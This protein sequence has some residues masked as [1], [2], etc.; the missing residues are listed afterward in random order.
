VTVRSYYRCDPLSS[1]QVLKT[2]HLKLVHELFVVE[3]GALFAAGAAANFLPIAAAVAD[4]DQKRGVVAVRPDPLLAKHAISS[5]RVGRRL[6]RRLEIF[7][8][9]DAA[10]RA[11]VDVCIDNGSRGHRVG[12][13]DRRTTQCRSM[14]RPATTP[15]SSSSSVN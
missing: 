8:D 11:V 5:R 1:L 9:H 7:V 12:A 10:A 14:T 3:C 6:A 2:Q 4:P 13:R 15:L